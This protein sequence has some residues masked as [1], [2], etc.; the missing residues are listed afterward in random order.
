MRTKIIIVA[1]VV[2]AIAVIVFFNREGINSETEPEVD[3]SPV[4]TE[5][6]MD[7][8][9]D[10]YNDWLAARQSTTTNPIAAGFVERPVLSSEVRSYI[11]DA[12]STPLPSG[13]EA[14]L[15]QLV[16]PE[17]IGAKIMYQ[18]E[19]TAQ[20]MVL[21]RGGEKSPYQAQVDLKAVG[22]Q[23]QISK[24]FCS[25]GEVAPERE[26]GFDKEG[27]LLKSV[28]PPLD[29]NYWHLV[30]E[31]NGVLGHTVPLSFNQD[32]VCLKTDGAMSVCDPTSFIEPT[33]VL[34]QAEMLETGA[35]VKKLHFR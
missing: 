13:Q 10:F 1:L 26:F 23:W 27:Y 9:I 28:P 34:V 17:R 32:S 14:V 4:P 30:Y 7:V 35:V 24:I 21:A 5:E 22:G 2:L 29:S 20:V 15:C 3:G 19:L 18:K 8:T 25:Q 12:E 6:P 11:M 16:T 33:L 31:E